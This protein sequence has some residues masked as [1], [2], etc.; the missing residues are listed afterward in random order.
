MYP[1]TAYGSHCAR[2]LRLVLHERHSSPKL[3]LPLKSGNLTGV[4]LI[5]RPLLGSATN[6]GPTSSR[7]CYA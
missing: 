1:V 6:L 7:E 4:G 5:Y 3:D 2:S